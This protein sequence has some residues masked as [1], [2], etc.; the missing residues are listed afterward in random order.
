M[1]KE[2][3][4]D[5]IVIGGGPAGLTA[6]LYLARARYRVLVVEK[7]HFG[8]QITITSEVVNYPGIERTNGT[9]LTNAMRKQAQNF[10]AEFLLAEAENLDFSGDIKMV[11]TNKGRLKCFGVLLATGAHPRMI[12]FKGEAEF[13]GH[14]V[15]Y[16]A[17]CDGEFFTG[18][19]VFVVGGGFAAAEESVF[20]TQY[21]SHVTILVREDDFTCAKATAEEA[22]KNEKITVLTNTEVVEA[23][24]DDFLRTLKYKNNV[25][26]EVTEYKAPKGDTFGIFVFA[27]YEPATELVRGLADINEQ[28]Y[29][30]TDLCQKTS[31][32]GLYA[33]GD[34]CVKN[35]RQVVT[36]VGDGALAATELERYAKSMQ[37]KTGIKPVQPD[38]SR[39]QHKQEKITVQKDAKTEGENSLFSEDMLEQL[40]VVFDKM[41]RSLLLKL[42]LKDDAVSEELKQYME[43]LADMTDKLTLEI[44]N[45]GS[46]KQL[47]CVKVCLTD[48]TQTGLAF[49]GVPGGHEFTSFVLGLYNAAGPG[50]IVETDVEERIKNI[51]DNIHLQIMVS[52]SCTMCPDLVTSAQKI[53]AGNPNVIADVYD[54][55]HFPDL[56]D[57]YQVMSVPCMVINGEKPVFGKKNIRQIL[58]LIE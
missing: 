34:V 2:N 1:E 57:K 46:E 3:L 55:N 12:G 7:E 10:G 18:K 29:V 23:S 33:A 47:P 56:K 17:T 35:L 41:E 26:G 31:V 8:G 5:V 53:A 37:E 32:D 16:C 13:R 4:Y 27:G 58:D 50:Q 43:T 52:L 25:T 51:S 49:H 21:A 6:A 9:E 11:D 30:K 44:D 24:G 40:N 38:S 45:S 19:E 15:A 14:G 39:K 28:N 48:G 42:Y 20:L 36:A 22:R 54:L